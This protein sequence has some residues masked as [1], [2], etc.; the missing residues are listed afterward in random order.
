[1]DVE[2]TAVRKGCVE[3]A[4]RLYE[5]SARDFCKWWRMRKH[6]VRLPNRRARRNLHWRDMIDFLRRFGRADRRVIPNSQTECLVETR[7]QYAH[8]TADE[9]VGSLKALGQLAQSLY[10]VDSHIFEFSPWLQPGKA[11]PLAKYYINALE[12]V[13]WRTATLCQDDYPRFTDLH[14]RLAEIV[15]PQSA[16]KET[17]HG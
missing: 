2:Y 4:R 5:F 8:F 12:A 1:M 17:T 6:Q 13:V 14:T 10:G 9:L 3:R 11:N 15:Q 16:P 7:Q